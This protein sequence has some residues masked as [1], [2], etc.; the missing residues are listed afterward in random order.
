[1][2][3]NRRDQRLVTE[4]ALCLIGWPSKPVVARSGAN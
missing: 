1:M 3:Q 2:I 4:P